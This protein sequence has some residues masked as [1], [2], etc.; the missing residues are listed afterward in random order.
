MV[1]IHH[2]ILC[3]ELNTVTAHG[4]QN[5]LDY[6]GALQQLL[7]QQ[8]LCQLFRDWELSQPGGNN[9]RSQTFLAKLKRRRRVISLSKTVCQVS[10]DKK[11]AGERVAWNS[12]ENKICHQYNEH[13]ALLSRVLTP[14]KAVCFVHPWGWDRQILLR[15]YHLWRYLVWIKQ[16]EI[17]GV[18]LHGVR[19]QVKC[20]T[21]SE[22]VRWTVI[23]L[24]SR[25]SQLCA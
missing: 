23:A 14:T 21:K 15:R 18:P 20:L 6:L 24:S 10:E 13:R 1:H 12:T 16:K 19:H 9:S 22:L 3:M 4:V 8:L 5:H 11:H 17:Y 7:H 2:F 25:Y